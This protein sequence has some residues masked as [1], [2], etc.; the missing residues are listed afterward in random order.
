MHVICCSWPFYC[1]L[2]R[3]YPLQWMRTLWMQNG[4]I[5]SW[6]WLKGKFGFIWI[7]NLKELSMP[8]FSYHL[9]FVHLLSKIWICYI[10]V[11]KKITA[12]WHLYMVYT[13]KWFKK[14][15]QDFFIFKGWLDHSPWL[16]QMECCWWEPRP[17]VQRGSLDTSRMSGSTPLGFR[18]GR[19]TLFTCKPRYLLHLSEAGCSML[20]FY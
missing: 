5:S 18:T 20:L 16:T 10:N 17:R 8:P 11:N 12:N 13:Y 3:K 1:R 14:R 6:Q 7:V 4:T 19:F 15:T 2:T 9:I